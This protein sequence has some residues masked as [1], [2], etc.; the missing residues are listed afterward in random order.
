[1]KLKK[2]VKTF[3]SDFKD[4]TTLKVILM[5]HAFMSTLEVS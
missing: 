3:R 5:V 2:K 1:M 4:M